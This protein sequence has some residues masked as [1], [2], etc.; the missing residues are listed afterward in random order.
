[1]GKTMG[2]ALV[3]T[4]IGPQEWEIK[5]I[6]GFGNKT[7]GDTVLLAGKKPGFDMHPL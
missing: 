1:M 6:Q 2:D 4:R 3:G 7:A 5:Q